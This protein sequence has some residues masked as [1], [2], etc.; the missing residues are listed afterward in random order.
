MSERI[1]FEAPDKLKGMVW[2]TYGVAVALEALGGDKPKSVLPG[3]MLAVA[4]VEVELAEMRARLAGEVYRAAAKAGH[5]ITKL[6]SIHTCIKNGVP[7]V[8]VEP[9]DLI[10]QT[11]E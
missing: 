4:L 1:H 3:F 8:E 5:D 10:D 11:V 6:A 2:E 7:V 9:A